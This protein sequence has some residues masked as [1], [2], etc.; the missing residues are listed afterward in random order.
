MPT[1]YYTQHLTN[2]EMAIPTSSRQR[3]ARTSAPSWPKPLDPLLQRIADLPCELHQNILQHLTKDTQF[4]QRPY[5]APKF[6][7]HVQGHRLI[8]S[9][10]PKPPALLQLDQC[11]RT[12]LGTLYYNQKTFCVESEQTLIAWLRSLEP[13]HRHLISKI[14][15]I[16][17]A[18]LCPCLGRTACMSDLDD[19]AAR[20]ARLVQRLK[21][22]DLHPRSEDAVKIWVCNSLLSQSGWDDFGCENG[23]W[24]ARHEVIFQHREQALIEKY[25]VDGARQPCCMTMANRGEY[26]HWPR[27]FACCD[28]HRAR[29][30]E[31]GVFY[32]Q[33]SSDQ[34]RK[35]LGMWGESVDEARA[36]RRLRTSMREQTRRFEDEKTGK[37]D[38]VEVARV[39]AERIDERKRKQREWD[40][41]VGIA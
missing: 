41:E 34:E 32:G 20:L 5:G 12:K 24:T 18:S 10:N 33:L 40:E 37:V 8:S 17:S 6:L 13:V 35:D 25:R 30:D 19:R 27:N 15:F 26:Q 14:C 11:A 4:A 9:S 3:A 21:A 2:R 29:V 22:E 28:A 7:D 39:E 16:P 23:Y 38:A 36:R 1:G 31:L